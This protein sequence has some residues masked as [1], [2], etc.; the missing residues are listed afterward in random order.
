[1]PEWTPGHWNMVEGA[2][3]DPEWP[4]LRVVGDGRDLFLVEEAGYEEARLA[5]AAPDLYKALADLV[6][7][8]EPLERD[9]RLDVPGLATLNRHRAALAK[10]RG[11]S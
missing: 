1:M 8:L 9:G 11:E 6:A 5:A 2:N 7:A 4:D 3:N 10:A